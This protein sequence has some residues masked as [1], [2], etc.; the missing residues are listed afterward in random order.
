VVLRIIQPTH[1]HLPLLTIPQMPQPRNLHFTRL[2][3]HQPHHQ[4]TLLR[5]LVVA[6][7]IILRNGQRHNPLIRHLVVRLITRLIRHLAVQLITQ[8]MLHQQ[9]PRSIHHTVL[10]ITRPQV[11]RPTLLTAR[12]V[13]LHTIQ[14]SHQLIGRLC[15][16]HV[17]R[18]I[19]LLPHHLK[20]LLQTHRISQRSIRPTHPHLILHLFRR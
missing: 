1:L 15:L 18:H 6:L 14:L 16:L 4:I 10:Q 19:I 5:V 8:Q 3:H 13:G 12:A 2:I 9:F 11:H 7:H 20:H 17:A